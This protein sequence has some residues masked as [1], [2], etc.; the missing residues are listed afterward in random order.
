[1][2]AGTARKPA[3]AWEPM[4]LKSLAARS[5]LLP[6]LAIPLV[7]ACTAEVTDDAA[8]DTDISNHTEGEYVNANSALLWADSDYSEML[9]S[10][11]SLGAEVLPAALPETDPIAVR[12]QVWLDRLDGAVRAGF[13]SRNGGAELLAP[14]PRIRVLPSADAFNAWVSGVPGCI[15]RPVGHGPTDPKTGSIALLDRVQVQTTFLTCVSPASWKGPVPLQ[16]LLETTKATCKLTVAED[17]V[18]IGGSTCSGAGAKADDLA[19]FSTSPYVHFS[20]DLLYRLNEK[21]AAVVLA[22]ELGHYYRA[23]VSPFFQ[24]K[25]NFWFDRDSSSARRP[26]PAANAAELEKAYREV[27]ESAKPLGTET[28]V[29]R[30][31]ARLRPFLLQG[32]APK[33]LERREPNFVCK[34]ARDLLERNFPTLEV[35]E[36]PSKETQAAFVA[37]ENALAACAPKIGFGATANEKTLRL[38][39]VILAGFAHKTGTLTLRL[40]STLADVLD[41]QN[42]NAKKLDDKAKSLV[43]RLRDNGIGLY[44][45]EQE[46]DDMALE[47]SVKVGL[48]P[49][50]VLDGWVDFMRAI[51]D[52]Y[53]SILSPEQLATLRETELDAPTCKS[54]LDANWKR[55]DGTGRMVPVTVKL[56]QLDEPHHASC[57]R[58][59]NLWRESKVHRYPATRAPEPLVPAWSEL[60]AQAKAL[61]GR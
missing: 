23:H 34:D 44:T 24:Q 21:S 15:G 49:N 33:L 12:L 18:E 54:L 28:F 46:A 47:L 45:T 13:K 17:R 59:Y 38:S 22:H 2:Q 26:L 19:F 35:G 48:T 61:S 39:D 3:L 43:K 56:G 29:S 9:R 6:L 52:L 37:F 8:T 40:D 57:Y 42:A 11:E 20:T 25:Y 36:L 58:L 51:D 60:Q 10:R 16:S 27:V 31:S 30:Y 14:K 55:D 4:R 5:F 50:E 53:S 1:M 7:L 32:I 41:G